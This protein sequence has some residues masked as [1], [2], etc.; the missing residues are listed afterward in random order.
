M[1]TYES[2]NIFLKKKSAKNN[3]YWMHQNYTDLVFFF[4][5]ETIHL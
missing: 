3:D 1:P 2:E 5:G 4:L